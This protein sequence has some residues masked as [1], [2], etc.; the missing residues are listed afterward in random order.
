MIGSACSPSV[1][2]LKQS[3]RRRTLAMN[4]ASKS[5]VEHISFFGR[6]NSLLERGSDP[7]VFRIWR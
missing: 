1:R 7:N 3:N 2:T 6:W 4:T 5:M